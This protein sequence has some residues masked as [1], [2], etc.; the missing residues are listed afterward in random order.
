MRVLMLTFVRMVVIMRT[1]VC[2]VLVGVPGFGR[3]GVGIIF[4]SVY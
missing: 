1:F 2:M 3:I 4:E